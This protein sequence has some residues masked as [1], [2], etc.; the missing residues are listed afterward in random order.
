MRRKEMSFY[1]W[2]LKMEQM[3]SNSKG[4]LEEP[5]TVDITS[6][7]PKLLYEG[8]VWLTSS[9]VWGIRRRHLSHILWDQL[10]VTKIVRPEFPY[11]TLDFGGRLELIWCGAFSKLLSRGIVGDSQDVGKMR[12]EVGREDRSWDKGRRD[13]NQTYDSF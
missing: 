3:S 6:Q 1:I 5:W 9:L 13:K 12:G 8:M 11:W 10:A 2:G 4:C 7:F